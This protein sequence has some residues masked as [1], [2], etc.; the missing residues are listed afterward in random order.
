MKL[1]NVTLEVSAKPFRDS[2]KETMEK[3][4][5]KLFRQWEKL[6]THADMVS[7]MLWLSDG[8]E[9]LEYKGNPDDVFEWAYWQGVASRKMKEDEIALENIHHSPVK[10]MEDPPILTYEWIKNLTS[11]IKSVGKKISGKE[12]RVGS[13]F[14]PGPEFAISKFKYEKHPEIAQGGSMGSKTFVTCN[15]CLHEDKEVYAGF[16]DGIEEGTSLGTFLGRQA[17]YFMEDLGYDYIWFSNGFGF[18]LEAWG[19]K[20]ALFDGRSFMPEKAGE[21]AE[22]ILGFWRDF[23]L[24]CPFP[25]ET[26]GSNMTAG[27]EI[28]KD[29]CP[30][31]DI[32]REFKP[33][34]PINSPWAA[35]NGD[36][37][38]EFTGW[39]SHIA[40]APENDFSFRF[41]THDPWFLNSPWLDRYQREPHDIYMPLSFSVIDKNGKANVPSGIEFLTVDDSWGEMPEQVPNEVVPHILHAMRY[42]PDA[43]GP[44]VYLY[45]FDEYHEMT[46][47]EKPLINE[48]FANEWFISGAINNGLPLNTVMSFN[49]FVEN[50]EALSSASC[51]VAPANA[52]HDKSLNTLKTFIEKGGNALLFGPL[53][54]ADEKVLELL[55]LRL[56]DGVEGE[57][58]FSC[59]LEFDDM[60]E[61][62]FPQKILHCPVVS[63]GAICES[64]KEDSNA[65]LLTEA[66]GRTLAVCKYL[67]KGKVVWARAV[68]NVDENISGHIPTPLDPKSFFPFENLMRMALQRFGINISFSKREPG[69][70]TPVMTV[71]RHKN[72]FYFSGFAPNMNVKENF[73]L[74]WG[75]PV[76]K[77][78]D[79][80]AKD[81]FTE[82]QLPKSWHNECRIFVEQ[83]ECSELSCLEILPGHPD[84]KKRMSVRGLKNADIVFF[85]ETGSENKTYVFRNEHSL[86]TGIEGDAGIFKDY[87]VVNEGSGTCL[88]MKNVSGTLLFSW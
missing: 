43:P 41:Y 24:E 51:L 18:G 68:N 49:S 74:P 75:A 50:P 37:G 21:N 65:E 8:S 66:G 27:L 57:L 44:L 46:F 82:Y 85:P 55:E 3:V 84:Y 59:S 58:D 36:F 34:P 23:S 10:Y 77:C 4:C 25:V 29:A 20:G 64:L 67:G 63:G 56:L 80:L 60:R 62:A 28:A 22:G 32:Y 33:A 39:M 79:C 12:I 15:T 81:G 45:P 7:V 30:L 52:L 17:K 47:G 14:D 11:T 2:S 78:M 40:E 48:I 9:I 76:F 16:P 1:K 73:R 6:T 19:C 5:N 70:D 71:S 26:R 31:R 61:S 87:E 38:L 69:L 83:K 54:N 72:G 35:I 42:E 88:K 13:T 53:T 86:H